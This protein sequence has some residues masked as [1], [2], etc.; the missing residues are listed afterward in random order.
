VRIYVPHLRRADDFPFR[1]SLCD[2]VRLGDVT[3]THPFASYPITVAEG[4][5]FEAGHCPDEAAIRGKRAT[6]IAMTA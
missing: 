6:T 2:L 1:V 4:K 3:R 5:T